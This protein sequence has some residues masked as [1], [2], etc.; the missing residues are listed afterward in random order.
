[1]YGD[2]KIGDIV[3]YWSEGFSRN[4]K[5]RFWHMTNVIHRLYRKHYA[6]IKGGNRKYTEKVPYSGFVEILYSH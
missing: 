2:V 1:M 3:S 5:A 6:L 4:G